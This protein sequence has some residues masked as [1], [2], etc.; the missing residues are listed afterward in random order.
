MKKQWG[1][2]VFF[3][4]V[5]ALMVSWGRFDTAMAHGT[6]DKVITEDMLCST[7][8]EDYK[9]NMEMQREA[10]EGVYNQWFLKDDLQTV[11]IEIDENN[12]NYLFQN[13]MDKPYVMTKSVTI[14]EETIGFTGLKTKGNYTL[15]HTFTDFPDSDRFSFTIHFG[16]YIKKKDYGV[17]QNFYG[18]SKISF[19]NFFFDKS[20]MKEYAA[21]MLMREMGVPTPQFGLA[22]LYINGGYYGV[23]FMVEAMNSSILEQYWNAASDEV[24]GY[25]AKPY[26]TKLLYDKKLDK[27]LT[28]DGT[29]DLSPVLKQT[30]DGSYEASG[31]LLEQAGLW[32]EEQDT[33]EDVAADLP[34]VLLWE[35]KL[36]LLSEGKDFSGKKLDVNSSEYLELLESIM[37]VDETIRY[38]AA[39]SFLVQ[40]DYMFFNDRNFGLYVGT[41]GKST[42]IPWDYDLSFGCFHPGTAEETANYDIDNMCWFDG[43]G[44]GSSKDS[45]MKYIYNR[46]PVFHVIYQ[47]EELME[48]Y[49]AYL[50]DCSKIAFLGG[51]LQSGESYEPCY[52]NSYIDGLKETLAAAAKESLAENVQYL[53]WT[54]QPVGV[55]VGLPNLSKIIAMRSLGVY[56]QL[57]QMDTV[58]SGF[59]CDLS[60]LGNGMRSRD[61]ASQGNIINVDEKTGMFL[62]ADYGGGKQGVVMRAPSFV[63]EEVTAEEEVYAQIRA[64][65]GNQKE[66]YLKIYQL[67]NAAQAEDGYELTIPL[68]QEQVKS[69]PEVYAYRDGK[70][71]K[72]EMRI[73]DNLY[74][75]HLSEMGYL[76]VVDAG[77]EQKALKEE[78]RQRN[79]VVGIGGCVLVLVGVGCWFGVRRRRRKVEK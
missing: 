59:G 51:T 36:N 15:E 17:K 64:A 58:V 66:A 44:T 55:A 75:G 57:K 30:E 70:V 71:Q 48:K 40:L 18:C 4:A 28:E 14:G 53:N 22:K 37:D 29:F 76:L 60:A 16:K 26:N 20:M 34:T 54:T 32:E 31:A 50:M 49:H 10:S 24:D 52:F 19:N 62:R 6:T 12:L 69:L 45:V 25:L 43:T 63:V 1:L 77:G 13:A 3:A 65:V 2:A 42:M 78:V 8:D 67:S 9:V 47:N 33:L 27:F 23:Y 41:D 21:L 5:M 73:E 38:F 79:M 74:S 35:K 11:S 7:P 46:H 68:S 72:L 61:F 56:A 39:H